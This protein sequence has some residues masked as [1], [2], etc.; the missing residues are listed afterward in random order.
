M[1]L[2]IDKEIGSGYAVSISMMEQQD[3][4]PSDSPGLES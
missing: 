4:G 2:A 3:L 1:N